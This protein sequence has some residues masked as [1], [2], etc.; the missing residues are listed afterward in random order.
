MS[1]TVDGR[2]PSSR[3]HAFRQTD[4]RSWSFV[5]R[6]ID[7]A[8]AAAG[9]LVAAPLIVVL[10]IAIKLDTRGPILF[11][12]TRVGRGGK[13]I[14]VVKLRSMTV[15]A[16]SKGPGVTAAGD[17]RVTRVGAVLR[18]SKLDEL[19]QLWNVL[20]GDMSIVGPRPELP[21]YVGLYRQE[22]RRILDVRPGITDTAS[23]TFRDEEGL[24]AQAR[25]RER[26]YRE[27][28][29][30]LKVRLALEDVE[31]T[32]LRH[33]LSV[34]IKTVQAVLRPFDPGSDPILREAEEGIAR[35]N[36]APPS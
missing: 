22:W 14:W 12:Q 7:I 4:A 16:E 17:P 9:L 34:V 2:Q 26:A 23:L 31:R 25:D 3:W 35:L 33:D 11:W 28:L 24:L 13:A 20:V 15:D 32:S 1:D 21:R 27:V 10:A 29:L 5:K 8:I 19:P 6:L 18:R 30:P 36:E